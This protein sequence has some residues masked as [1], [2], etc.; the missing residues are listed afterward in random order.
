VLE[1][2]FKAQDFEEKGIKTLGVRLAAKEVESIK[3]DGAQMEL[4]S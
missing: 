2:A 4:F 1:E 3:V